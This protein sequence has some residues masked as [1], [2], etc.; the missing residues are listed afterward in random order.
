MAGFSAF[1]A[2]LVSVTLAIAFS[3]GAGA[4]STGLG[5]GVPSVF[6]RSPSSTT[7]AEATGL[8]RT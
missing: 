6:S 1:V 3:A 7:G 5:A 2:R 4:A 8:S